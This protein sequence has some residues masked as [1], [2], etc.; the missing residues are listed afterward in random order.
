MKK[1]GKYIWDNLEVVLMV[2]FL[3]AFII[4]VFLQI[5][6]RL[7]FEMPLSFTEEVSRYLFIWMVFLALP[8]STKYEKHISLDMV[9]KR[10]PLTL[11]YIVKILINLVTFAVFVWVLYY[12]I[13]YLIFV[14]AV[15]TPVLQLSKA[16]VAAIIPLSAFLMLLRTGERFV[17]EHKKYLEM[18]RLK[19]EEHNT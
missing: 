11:Q 16:L 17:I 3:D 6:T 19:K 18:R 4:N 12:G 1:I 13:Q 8:Y 14:K 7:F 5:L 9:Q 10:L 2:I 15:K